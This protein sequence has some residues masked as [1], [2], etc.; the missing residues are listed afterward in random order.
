MIVVNFVAQNIANTTSV[1]FADV[2]GFFKE[3]V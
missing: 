1:S 3:I 2:N